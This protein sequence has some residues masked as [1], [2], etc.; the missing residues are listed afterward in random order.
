MTTKKGGV[1]SASWPRTDLSVTADGVS[2]DPAFAF[3]SHAEFLA[4]GER[5]VLVRG[6]LVL[7]GA[8]SD[9]VLSRLQ[10]GGV[11]QTAVHQHLPDLSQAIWWNHIAARGDPIEIARTINAALSVSDT[12]MESTDD[13]DT[14]DLPLDTERLDEIMGTTGTVKSG[15]YKYGIPYDKQ[16]TLDGVAVPPTM[17]TTMPL[18]FQPLGGN[19]AAINGDFIMVASEV[20]P[21]IRALQRH[22]IR[23][24]SL[25]NHFLTDEPRLFFMHFWATG[26]ATTL[27]TGLRAALE[28]TDIKMEC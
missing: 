14:N 28:R 4:V 19:N 23:V 11:E 3:G 12:P 22:D 26:E 25:H 2:I 17:G 16:V 24:V 10:A 8:E 18:A 15:I 27:A 6:D 5:E 9:R 1:Y 20:N 13:P 21:V 7:T